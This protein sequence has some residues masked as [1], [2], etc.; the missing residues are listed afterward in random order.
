MPAI[1]TGREESPEEGREGQKGIWSKTRPSE[2]VESKLGARI[3][4]DALTCPWALEGD[5]NHSGGTKTK[6]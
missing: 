4:G 2:D 3:P 6:T 1:T 5:V